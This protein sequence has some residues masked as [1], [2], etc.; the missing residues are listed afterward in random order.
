MEFA[1][2]TGRAA[3]RNEM[4]RNS[5]TRANNK[6]KSVKICGLD[7]ITPEIQSNRGVNQ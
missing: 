7:C 5:E 1:F 6:V 3:P 4:Y 2:L